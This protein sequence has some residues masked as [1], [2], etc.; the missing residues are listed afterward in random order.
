MIERNAGDFRDVT[1][2]G[3]QVFVN[4]SAGGHLEFELKTKFIVGFI[5]ILAARLVSGK[6][7]GLNY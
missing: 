5:E 3:P 6:N 7:P 4:K 2:H 1:Q